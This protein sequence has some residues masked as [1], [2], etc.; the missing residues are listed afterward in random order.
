MGTQLSLRKREHSSPHF[1]T[2]VYCGQTARC[3]KIPLGR[4]VGFGSGHNVLDGEPVSPKKGGTVPPIFVPCLL[5]PNGWMDQDAT[6]YRDRPGCRPHCIRWAT[7][8]PP[9]KGHSSPLLGPCLLRPNDRP[10]QLLLSSCR[11]AYGRDFLCFTVCIK[12]QLTRQLTRLK[13]SFYSPTVKLNG[14]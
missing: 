12:T 8:L 6:W 10:S 5:W 9:E 3:I 11:T 7:E 2:H 1:L 13:Y 14:N 4:E